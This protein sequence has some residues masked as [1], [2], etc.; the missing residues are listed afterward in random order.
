[1]LKPFINQGM[2]V[3]GTIVITPKVRQN[4]LVSQEQAASVLQRQLTMQFMPMYRA[5]QRSA[6]LKSD[7]PSE[8][9]QGANQ[10][11]KVYKIKT[12]SDVTDPTN[13]QRDLNV[14]TILQSVPEH[15]R[16]II[17]KVD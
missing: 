11:F 13:K 14:P 10:P 4:S 5:R 1:M 3:P 6:G 17:T 8:P 12:Q 7:K 16:D 15:P 2:A 9:D